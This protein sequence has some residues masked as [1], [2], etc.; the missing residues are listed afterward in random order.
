MCRDATRRGPA[1]WTK[2]CSVLLSSS[3]AAS[4]S[5]FPSLCSPSLSRMQTG[6]AVA[7]T[8][9]R[10]WIG[11]NERERKR[12]TGL[13]ATRK[14]SFSL[15]LSIVLAVVL[16]FFFSALSS[17]SSASFFWL[18]LRSFFCTRHQRRRATS[19]RSVISRQRNRP[20]LLS[21]SLAFYKAHI[22]KSAEAVSRI[23]SEHVRESSPG[24]ITSESPGNVRP[25]ILIS[26]TRS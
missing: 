8:K 20:F 18:F 1:R 5:R 24:S 3:G 16:R 13:G 6:S 21:L 7:K 23:P 19:T 15:Y 9:R 17:C 14:Q 22:G 4:N 12:R 2:V 25:E 10:G 26:P 11:E